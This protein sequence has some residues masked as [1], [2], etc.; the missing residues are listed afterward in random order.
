MKKLSMIA[1]LILVSAA[2]ALACSSTVK[3]PDEL[4]GTWEPDSTFKYTLTLNED[5]TY[6]IRA[7]IDQLY[8]GEWLYSIYSGNPYIT[9]RFQ[10]FTYLDHYVIPHTVSTDEG[11]KRG[12]CFLLAYE[13]NG[14]G[15]T[16]FNWAHCGLILIETTE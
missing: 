15:A 16:K 8:E 14:A 11:A 5:C 6:Q 3:P 7:P 1:T 10:E 9:L 13:E 12:L 2:G 4:I